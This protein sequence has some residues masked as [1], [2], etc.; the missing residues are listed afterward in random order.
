M[1]FFLFCSCCQQTWLV[2]CR[3]RSVRPSSFFNPIFKTHHYNISCA[4]T[5]SMKPS[6]N[7][8]NKNI[9]IVHKNDTPGKNLRRSEESWSE[10]FLCDILDSRRELM[11]KFLVDKT[12]QQV[13]PPLF[14]MC[15]NG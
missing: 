6:T 2:Y 10:Q 8:H 5:V 12:S 9:I 15:N 13:W 7:M 14:R 11:K 3:K 1:L 4:L